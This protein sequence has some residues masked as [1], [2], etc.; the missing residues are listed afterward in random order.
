MQ[1][2]RVVALD[3]SAQYAYEDRSG[4]AAVFD[5]DVP[6]NQTESIWEL[7]EAEGAVCEGA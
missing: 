4:A 1:V 7:V 2:K 3:N 6:V 5:R